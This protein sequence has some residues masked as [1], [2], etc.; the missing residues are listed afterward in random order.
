MTYYHDKRFLQ[1]LDLPITNIIEVGARYGNESIELS[2]IFPDALIYSFECN[3]LTIDMARKNLENMKNIFFFDY[4]LGDKNEYVP[5]YSYMKCNDGA[6]SLLKRIDFKETQ[7]QTG[8]T[9]VKKLVDVIKE[10]DIEYI[11]LL[12][13]NVQGYELNIL[14][15]ADDFIKNI[16]FVIMEEPKPIINENYLP[17]G[18]HSKYMGAPTPQE[19]RQF[20]IDNNFTEIV[21]IDENMIEDNVMYKNNL[22]SL[23]KS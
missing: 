18:V 3:P 10:I 8:L 16:K 11:D 20:M 22:F 15:G 13:M 21:R 19:I 9:Y 4:G 2:K 5:F 12:C 6:S 14:K 1:H 23:A 17:H 7:R